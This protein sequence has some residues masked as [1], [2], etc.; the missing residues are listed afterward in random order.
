MMISGRQHAGEDFGAKVVLVA[1][2]VG[3]ALD[4]AGLVVEPLDEAERDLVLPPAVGRA[5]VPLLIAH[6]G[7]FL[8][9]REPLPLEA[10]APVLEEAPRPAFTFIAPQLDE[11]L[12][13]NIGRVEPFVGRQQYLQR[14]LAVE[15]E[16]LSAR[17]QRVFLALDV[18]PLAIL[19]PGILALANRIQGLPQMADDMELVEQ[20]RRLWRM[21]IRR[22][23]ER[24]PH[25]HDGEA[26]TR[27]LLLA[28]PGVELAHARLR[29]I[30]AAKP[31]RP[32][33]HKVA[34]NDPV[35][36]SF[37]DRYLVDADHLRPGRAHAL[38]LGFHVLLV[39]RLDRVPVQRQVLSHV[40]DRCRPTTLAHIVCKTLG[41]ERIVRQ[42]IE[43]FLLHL[44]TT[45]AL[46]PPQ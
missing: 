16:I 10:C 31:D 9:R 7:E 18:A 15:R 38:E 8:I 36:V 33:A 44:A 14:L 39:Q 34:D 43:P 30:L 21:R 46:E 2:A 25:V 24:L 22:Q 45:A 17:E 29:T 3:A 32:P 12:L 28:E 1:Q 11:A 19:A 26:N 13:E 23:A 42:K 20:N 5:A 27:T 4:D 35:I 40:L 41:V 37:A 6:L